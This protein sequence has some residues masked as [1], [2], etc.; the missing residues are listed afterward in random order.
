MPGGKGKDG[1]QPEIPSTILSQAQAIASGSNSGGEAQGS[2]LAD[3][4]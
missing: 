4:K 1:N 2:G 3:K